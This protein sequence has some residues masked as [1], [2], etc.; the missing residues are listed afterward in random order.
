METKKPVD[1]LPMTAFPKTIHNRPWVLSCIVLA[2]APL[3]TLSGGPEWKRPGIIMA[4][5]MKQRRQAI[6][7]P[8]TEV[9]FDAAN[10][11]IELAFFPLRWLNLKRKAAMAIIKSALP[12]YNSQAFEYVV[13]LIKIATG[14]A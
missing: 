8:M 1:T 3:S 12:R 11:V 6:R 13:S 4:I 2:G 5:S 9:I 14:T 10:M 7:M